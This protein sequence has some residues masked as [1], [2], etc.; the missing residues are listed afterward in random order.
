M[1]RK[2]NA[3]KTSANKA[4]LAA[5][6]AESKAALSK[7]LADK[8]IAAYNEAKKAKKLIIANGVESETEDLNLNQ[9]S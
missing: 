2:Y 9:L 1:Q 5:K 7:A 8:A 3:A 6:I 4:I